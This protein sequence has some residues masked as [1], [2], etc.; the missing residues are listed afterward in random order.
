MLNVSHPYPP[1]TKFRVVTPFLTGDPLNGPENQQ[2]LQQYEEITVE[3]HYDADDTN[4]ED[5]SVHGVNLSISYLT[6]EEIDLYCQKV[7]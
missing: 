4:P 7:E 2:T 5:Y 1:G 3:M 6:A